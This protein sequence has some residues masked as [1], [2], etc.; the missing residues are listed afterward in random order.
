MDNSFQSISLRDELASNL[1]QLGL[2]QMTEI[3]QHSLPAI[4][5]VKM[6]WEKPKPV[7]VKPLRCSRGAE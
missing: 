2:T 1:A 5:A 7:A 3:Q 4:L 6:F